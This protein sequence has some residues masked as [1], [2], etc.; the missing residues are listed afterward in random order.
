[1]IL[2]NFNLYAL[3]KRGTLKLQINNY[4]YNNDNE[5][6]HTNIIYLGYNQSMTVPS[7]KQL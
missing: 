1:M 5:N 3:K 7:E 2:G 6:D 4:N